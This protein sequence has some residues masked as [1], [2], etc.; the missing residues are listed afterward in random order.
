MDVISYVVDSDM[1]HNSIVLG[2]FHVGF[3]LHH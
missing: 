1:R 3:G 2:F